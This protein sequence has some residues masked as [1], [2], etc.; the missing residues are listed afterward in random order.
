MPYLLLSL[1]VAFGVDRGAEIY[2][3]TGMFA[4]FAFFSVYFVLLFGKFR[5][6]KVCWLY[7][8]PMII[9]NM[10]VSVFSFYIYMSQFIPA[11]NILIQFFYLFGSGF[12]YVSF[13]ITTLYA[14]M[15]SLYGIYFIW[16]SVRKSAS[17][18]IVKTAYLFTLFGYLIYMCMFWLHNSLVFNFIG[19][20][21]QEKITGVFNRFT[22][23]TADTLQVTALF[24]WMYDAGVTNLFEVYFVN[25]LQYVAVGV[26]VGFIIYIIRL[27]IRLVSHKDN[28][29]SVDAIMLEQPP[30][31]GD[32]I[33]PD[34]EL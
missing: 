6:E 5:Y 14:L 25:F 3:Y 29:Q 17:S 21:M 24:R 30:V 4:A 27:I 9:L 8:R 23:F 18:L 1:F 26:I 19:L 2:E 10:V 31:R 22:F 7:S 15:F 13:A 33:P 34:I 11:T 12:A 32:E 20:E 16:C 28:K